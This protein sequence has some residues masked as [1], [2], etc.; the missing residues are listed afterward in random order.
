[1]GQG[2][3]GFGSQSRIRQP[4]SPWVARRY[5]I[6]KA[7]R[8]R[9]AFCFRRRASPHVIEPPWADHRQVIDPLYADHRQVID[10]LYAGH[11]RVIDPLYAGHLR[12]IDPP[13]A[14]HLRVIDPPYADHRQVIDPVVPSTR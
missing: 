13:Y 1:M 6:K 11:L 10:P 12:V 5:A 8:H 7:N 4:A 14:G 3:E 9:L 2:G